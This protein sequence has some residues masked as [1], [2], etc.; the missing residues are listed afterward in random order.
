MQIVIVGGGLAGMASALKL[1]DA[2][3]KIILLEK[4]NNLGGRASSI[5]DNTV[6]EEI[7]NAQHVL[8]GCCTELI[9]FYNSLGTLKFIKFFSKSYFIDIQKQVSCLK[10]STLTAPF[11]F[12]PSFLSFNSF[13][14]H[15]KLAI[16]RGLFKIYKTSLSDLSLTNTANYNMAHWLRKEGQPIG[17]IKKFWRYLIVSVLNDEP[18]NVNCKSAFLFF[19]EVFLK[20]KPFSRIGVSTVPL[21]NL[22]KPFFD[23]LRQNEGEIYLNTS[24]RNLEFSNGKTT[25]VHTS[26]GEKIEGDVFILAMPLRDAK[27]LLSS[28]FFLSP[29]PKEMPILGIHLWF[30]K[31]FFPYEFLG[32]I[33]SPIHWIFNK[34]LNFSLKNNATEYLH[35]L[36]SA[37]MDWQRLTRNEI[38]D[39]AL[40]ELY[41][42][43]PKSKSSK[44]IKSTTMKEGYAT[45][46]PTPDFEL[47]R[48]GPGTLIPNLFFAGDWIST[49]WPSTMESAVRSGNITA[50]A[51]FQSFKINP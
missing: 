27:R 31:R 41:Y 20:T 35:L 45:F 19:K 44:L 36:V 18:D 10:I 15:E 32:L 11:H 26:K 23:I 4:R 16:M 49:G 17:A 50:N 47:K 12:F 30:D 3:H 48:Q 14:F 46:S 8:M 33:E 42:Y 22:Y 29:I 9:E 21:S 13:K 28:N 7:D 34:S 5:Y 38:I 2:G 24:I 25:A 40:Q 6:N 51:I 39:L 37:S 1:V 43:S